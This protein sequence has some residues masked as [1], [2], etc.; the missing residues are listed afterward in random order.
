MFKQDESGQQV[1]EPYA[2]EA[3]YFTESRLL[4][5]DVKIIMESVSN[6]NILGTVLHPVSFLGGGGGGGRG[7][8]GQRVHFYRETSR[9]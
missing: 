7:E 8:G 9:S 5:R 1:A 3:K 4:Q 6:A 2:E